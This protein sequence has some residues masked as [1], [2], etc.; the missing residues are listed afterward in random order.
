MSNTDMI[1]GQIDAG[2]AALATEAAVNATEA[3]PTE[4]S[5]A[6]EVTE[7]LGAYGSRAEEAPV[8]DAPM[9]MTGTN[10]EVYG[11]EQPQDP[12]V[13]EPAMTEEDSAIEDMETQMEESLNEFDALDDLS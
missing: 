5:V 4:P 13:E 7:E 3:A 8:E 12:E 11:G 1:L 2:A 10:P 6:E 9:M